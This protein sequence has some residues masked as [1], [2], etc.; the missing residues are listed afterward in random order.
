[1]PIAKLIDRVKDY[2][3]E[4]RVVFADAILQSIN[5]IDPEIERKWIDLAQRRRGD[6]LM[7]RVEPISSEDVFAEARVLAGA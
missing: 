5:P 2:P 4:D 7:G 1:M 6:Y 3:I